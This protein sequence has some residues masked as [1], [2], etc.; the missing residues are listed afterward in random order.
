MALFD[1][2]DTPQGDN[3]AGNLRGQLLIATTGVNDGC[4]DKSVIYLCE[5]NAEGAM[6]VIVNH[7][8]ANIR[9]GE[10]LSALD[11]NAAQGVSDLPVF[12]GGPVEAHRGFVLHTNDRTAEDSV[13]GADGITLTAHIGMLKNIAAGDGPRQGF[14]VLG[15]AGWGAGQLEAELEAGS[16]IS[17]PAT[18]KLVFDTENEMK[19]SVAA[20][21]L[22]VDMHRLSNTV[23]HA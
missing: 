2:L 14:L 21:T 11:I 10:I 23:G 13:I 8:I 15:Y 6:G 19:W 17:V 12:F 4:F 9:L 5:H 18:R 1:A 22:G 20:A 7:P 3:P 16:W